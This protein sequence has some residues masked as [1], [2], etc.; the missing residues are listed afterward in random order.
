ML[1]TWLESVIDPAF[2][3]SSSRVS[4]AVFVIYC[5]GKLFTPKWPTKLKAHHISSLVKMLALN[6]D[7]ETSSCMEYDLLQ[8]QI[9]ENYR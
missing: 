4:V 3:E 7:I 9:P 5:F 6:W 2:K 8:S 1:F